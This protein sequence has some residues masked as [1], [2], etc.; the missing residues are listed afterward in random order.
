MIFGGEFVSG[1]DLV[2]IS[3]WTFTIFFFGLCFWLDRES[4]REGFPLEKD[5]T[6]KSENSG[7]FSMPAPKTFIL[8]N[9]RGKVMVP[10]PNHGDRRPIALKR[11]ADWAGAPFDPTGDPLA[12]GVGP[13]SYCERLDEPDLITDGRLRI[14]PYRAGDGYEVANSDADPRGMTVYGGDGKPGGVVTDLWVDRAEA[15]IRYL[16]VNAG[17]EEAPHQV[18][19]PMPFAIVKKGEK[20]VD[21]YAIFGEHFKS[22]PKLKNPDQVTRLEEDKIAG[23]FGGGTFYAS[24]ARSKPFV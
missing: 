1:I 23:F 6:G 16:E 14:V 18:L 21:V 5:E 3:L 4:H 19:V 2:D 24:P 11:V 13:G 12:D 9:N 8:P 7:V 17:T 22:V 10:G 15:I 20:R